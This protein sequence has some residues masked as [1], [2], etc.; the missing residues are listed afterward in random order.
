MLTKSSIWTL[1][2]SQTFLPWWVRKKLGRKF[3]GE[4]YDSFILPWS[5][6]SATKSEDGFSDYS[7]NIIS[8]SNEDQDVTHYSS[9]QSSDI[10]TMGGLLFAAVA[11]RFN[12]ID[13]NVN[14]L[15]IIF[16]HASNV[17]RKCVIMTKKINM[18]QIF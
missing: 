7:N 17:L 16:Y 14:N 8:L 5:K 12:Q 4:F 18:C 11:D 6:R 1:L 9:F 13:K 15:S 3:P 2:F 10:E